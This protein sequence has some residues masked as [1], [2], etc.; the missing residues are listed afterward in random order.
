[1]KDKE[2]IPVFVRIENGKMTCICKQDNKTVQPLY[3]SPNK[4]LNIS[5]CPNDAILRQKSST[6][7]SLPCGFFLVLRRLSGA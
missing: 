5:V 6:G 2:L 7:E 1:M 4:Y 3:C